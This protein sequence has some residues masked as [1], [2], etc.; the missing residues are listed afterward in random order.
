[1]MPD[2]T[3]SPESRVIA[4][5]R[6]VAGND[7]RWRG[8]LAAGADAVWEWEVDAGRIRCS[9]SWAVVFGSAPGERALTLEE[10][11]DRIHPED[12]AAT[13]A[14]MAAYLDEPGD[15]PYRIEHRLRCADGTYRWMLTRG[16]ILT[17]AS[18][19]RPSRVVGTQTDVTP[20]H[21]VE[22]ELERCRD[23][24]TL[25]HADLERVSRLK[26]D[27][28]ANMSHELRT[29]LSGVLAL[30]ETLQEEI[31]GTLNP[32]QKRAIGTI[33]ESGQH[34]AELIGD[35]LDLAKVESGNLPLALAVWE[36][37]ELCESS[38]RLIRQAALKRQ[39]RL[40]TQLPPPGCR[41][42]VDRR[43]FKQILVNLLTN[44]VKFTPAGGRVGL[45]VE[46]DPDAGRLRIEV[47]DTGTGIAPQDLPRVFERFFQAEGTFGHRRG[48]SGLGLSLVQGLVL[49]HGG[50]VAAASELGQG[51]RFTV[52]L[53]WQQER[54]VPGDGNPERGTAGMHPPGGW[55][56]L[57]V[58]DNAVI[59]RAL[60]VQLQHRGY[61]VEWTADGAAALATIRELRPEVVLLDVQMEGQ[62]GLELTR[63]VRADPDPT[64]AGL[65]IVALTALAMPGDQERCLAAGMNAYL[66]KPVP[67]EALEATLADV[68]RGRTPAPT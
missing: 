30:A 7:A 34:L 3:A 15:A 36:V 51:S 55:R 11:E 32:E 19:G 29:P 16:G 17:R 9:A 10:W 68:Y 31:L 8:V 46:T 41:F 59:A 5:T 13:R 20:R 62:N 42:R 66:A 12:R 54:E 25:A 38:L 48:G 24:L 45:R 52:E 14:G 58:E 63:A 26:D 44:A 65:P 2:P 37:R 4:L 61:R 53:P 67:F 39:V 35:L 50:R 21:D 40:E 64:V 33:L 27:F 22:A 57:I 60:M 18:N 1:M 6:P 47:W 49:L 23:Q 28:L 56:V 43:R